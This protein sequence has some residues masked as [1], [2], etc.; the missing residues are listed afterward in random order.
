MKNLI[1][2]SQKLLGYIDEER[3]CYVSYRTRSHQFVKFGYGFGLS[4]GILDLLIAHQIDKI[5]I[6]FEKKKAYWTYPEVF[7]SKGIDWNDNG[8]KQL[9]LPLKFWKQ[10]A[11][12]RKEIQRVL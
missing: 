10:E 7:L 6:I 4:E 12:V 1:F 11:E 9:I 5:I 8:D 2:L 3:N